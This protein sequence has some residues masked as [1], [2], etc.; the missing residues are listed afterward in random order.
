MKPIILFLCLI[1][2]T[3][4]FAQNEITY[5][6]PLFGK[7]KVDT[8]EWTLPRA[9]PFAM[10]YFMTDRD[11]YG[12][13]SNVVHKASGLKVF[14][15]N[16]FSYENEAYTTDNLRRMLSGKELTKN[17]HPKLKT[18][19]YDWRKEIGL[20]AEMHKG[21]FFVVSTNARISDTLKIQALEEL[22]SV[23]SLVEPSEMDQVMG[24]PL[25]GKDVIQSFRTRL[26]KEYIKNQ[27][28]A[29]NSTNYPKMIANPL[30]TVW[31]DENLFIEK[32][33]NFSYQKMLDIRR[34]DINRDFSTEDYLNVFFGD[35]KENPCAIG[36]QKRFTGQ[37]QNRET[38]IVPK[39]IAEDY[40]KASKSPIIYSDYTLDVDGF[41]LLYKDSAWNLLYAEKGKDKSGIT[42]WITY[43]HTGTRGYVNGNGSKGQLLN[44]NY[45]ESVVFG[46]PIEDSETIAITSFP[47]KKNEAGIRYQALPIVSVINTKSKKQKLTKFTNPASAKDFKVIMLVENEWSNYQELGDQDFGY[48]NASWGH[49]YPNEQTTVIRKVLLTENLVSKE[50]MNENQL[51]QKMTS[52]PMTQRL[53]IGPVVE[54]DLDNDGNRE[55]FRVFISNGTII[56]YEI[57]ENSK[58]GLVKVELTDVWKKKV[59]QHPFVSKMILLSTDEKFYSPYDE[60]RNKYTDGEEERGVNIA[61]DFEEAPSEEEISVFVSDLPVYPGGEAGLL[62]DLNANLIYPEMEREQNIYGTVYVGFIVEKDGSISNIEIIRAVADGPG[63]SKAAEAAVRKLKKFETPAKYNNK[64]VRYQY[65]LPVKFKID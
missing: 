28:V 42:K 57:F 51:E 32:R 30:D 62:S 5:Y 48:D 59:E 19:E 38:L 23:L 9:E 64:I 8:T 12:N 33:F 43:D 36:G 18:Y 22:M 50:G 55:V 3:A 15:R 24:Y 54:A 25:K 40:S 21:I 10:Y 47:N 2:G 16:E 27:L 17:F 37:W 31:F 4:G 58:S 39:Y 56:N 63:L 41:A 20:A 34:H 65:R 46:R 35:E 49:Y 26:I 13:Y 44:S 6:V 14:F 61:A 29:V 45:Y 7:L 1:L 60:E 11:V 52:Y 53:T